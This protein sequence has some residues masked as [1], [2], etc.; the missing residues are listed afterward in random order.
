MIEVKDNGVLE[1]LLHVSYADTLIDIVKWI[2][3]E[4][5]LIVI[6]CGYREDDMGVHGS[7]PCRGMDLRERCYSDPDMVA[8]RVN[9]AW[10][11]DPDRPDLQCAVL[12]GKGMN[13]HIHLQVHPNTEIIS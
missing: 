2:H 8:E 1:Q 7:I 12:H 9:D 13:R 10:Q 11:Y 3:R 4:Y 5:G 6:T